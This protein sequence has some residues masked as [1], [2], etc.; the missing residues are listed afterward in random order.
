M[1]FLKKLR[2]AILLR[3]R[4]MPFVIRAFCYYRENTGIC[5]SL[6]LHLVFFIAI[7]VDFSARPQKKNDVI[8]VPMFTVDL[9]K[10]KIAERTNLPP[11]LVEGKSS[12]NVTA[13]NPPKVKSLRTSV[14][15]RAS[16]NA[17][18]ESS[19]SYQAPTGAHLTTGMEKIISNVSSKKSKSTDSLTGLLNSIKNTGNGGSGSASSKPSNAPISPKFKTLLASIDGKADGSGDVPDE[20]IDNITELANTG[21]EGG[22]GGSYMQELTVSEKD[23]LGIK[24][25]GCWN[26]DAGVK[27]INNMLIEVRVYLDTDGK[28]KDARILDRGR[29]KKDS[30]FRSIAESARRAVYIC[31]KKDEESPFRIF[32]K[33]YPKQYEDWKTLLLR[34]NPMNGGIG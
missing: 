23:M 29:M 28:V 4:K 32:P 14:Y 7:T 9:T 8:S 3:L 10:V 27:G 15:S 21:I 13:N 12:G 26:I 33:H 17:G 6:M 5:L 11:K 22:S 19:A 20:I 18:S 30:A 16:A 2:F 34:F 24:L 1:N 25:R 31:D